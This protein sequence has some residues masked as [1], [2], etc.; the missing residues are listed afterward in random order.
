MDAL[1]KICN[2]YLEYLE[3][4][5]YFDDNDWAHYIYEAALR[6]VLGEDIFDRMRDIQRQRSIR[7]KEKAIAKLQSEIKGGDR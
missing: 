5:D 6:A 2:E 3:S 1:K 4:D 7:T